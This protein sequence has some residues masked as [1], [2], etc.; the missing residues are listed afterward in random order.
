MTR[1][2]SGHPGQ[3]LI[4]M[5]YPVIN[6]YQDSDISINSYPEDLTGCQYLNPIDGTAIHHK[7]LAG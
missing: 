3:W 4:L 2:L 5:S 6:S 1:T 7:Q